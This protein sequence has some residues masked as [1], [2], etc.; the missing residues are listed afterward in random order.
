MHKINRRAALA[1]GSG[2]L[3]SAE[4]GAQTSP[5]A[6]Q[7]DLQQRL[8]E[9][10]LQNVHPIAVTA[11]RFS[12]PGWD[13]LM[14]EARG[15]EFVMLGE[16][17]GLAETPILARE[18]FLALHPSGFDTLAIEI[19]RPIAE[20]LEEAA[21]D[22]LEGITAFA[23]KYPPGPAFYF[24]KPEAELIAAVRTAIPAKHAV[25][26]GLD[27]EMACDRRLIERLQAKVPGSA[28]AALDTLDR[29][30]ET[31]RET[32]RATRNP[33]A[34]F[35][36]S[37]DPE[38][39]RAVRRAWPS[40]DADASR[41]L[42]TLEETL[43]INRLFGSGK[44]WESNERRARFNRANL[45]ALLD[46]ASI[47]GRRPKVLF[48]M[49]ESHMMRGVNWTGNFDVGSLVP[50]IAAMRGG[51]TFSFLVGGGRNSHHGVLNPT[52][53]SVVD[54]PADMFEQLG[55]LFLANAASQPGPVLID[56]RP[57][58]ALVSSTR[59]QLALN[60]PE[61]VRNIH[62]FDAM[63]V[64]NGSTATRMLVAR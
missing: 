10:V 58:R 35:T 45:V 47:E 40:A 5:P 59:A 17:H 63:I 3:L 60:N 57:L 38:L 19:S 49:G 14:G 18:L 9:R 22:G 36:F 8:V 48:K 26:W 44:G 43:E 12:G 15:S 24:W 21:R 54:K 56:L 16:E 64:W 51:K 31:A 61:A 42:D 50:E 4:A 28:K 25:L 20:D 55:L 1:L 13:L 62:A 53:M 46:A 33:G 11:G 30:S 23:R 29:V 39:V 7:S 37:G 52:D 2:V 32:W 34:L 41:I 6:T 27:Y